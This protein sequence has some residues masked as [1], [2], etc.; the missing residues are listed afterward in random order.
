MVFNAIIKAQ[1]EI[2][3]NHTFLTVEHRQLKFAKSA[4][5]KKQQAT[6]QLKTSVPELKSELQNLEQTASII[7]AEKKEY[8][9][10]LAT[11]KNKVD[12]CL[13]KLFDEEYVED[14]V[15]SELDAT[16]R[17]VAEKE[18]HIEQKRSEEKRLV[19]MVSIMKEK[20]AIT[21]R[22]IEHA[23][24]MKQDIDVVIN[25]EAEIQKLDLERQ[26]KNAEIQTKNFSFLNETLAEEKKECITLI[27]QTKKALQE[28]K[29]RR[30]ALQVELRE[31]TLERDEKMKTLQEEIGTFESILIFGLF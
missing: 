14:N 23:E 22:K 2:K 24:Q 13:M 20:H 29:S 10:T 19:S 12:A 15:L 7:E 28:M 31:K 3:H 16:M 11:L 18:Y 21:R 9:N 8:E 1:E 6:A 26:I 5:V 17:Q 4:L 27:G 30:E 25:V